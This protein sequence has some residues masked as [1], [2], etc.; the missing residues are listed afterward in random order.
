MTDLG[1]TRGPASDSALVDITTKTIDTS[2][3]WITTVLRKHNAG[4]HYRRRVGVFTLG[5]VLLAFGNEHTA[6]DIYFWYS[7]QTS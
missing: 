3:Q 4:G 7:T 5:E 2:N 1:G 6:M